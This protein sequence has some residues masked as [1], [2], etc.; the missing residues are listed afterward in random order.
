[1]AFISMYQFHSA[2][3]FS[4]AAMLSLMGMM[5]NDTGGFLRCHMVGGEMSA[6]PEAYA[7][8]LD[9]RLLSP[10]SEVR[11]EGCRVVLVGSGGVVHNFDKVVLATT[12]DVARKI[13]TTPSENQ[14]RFLDS[15][16][17]AATVNV[18]FRVP[19]GTLKG[20]ACVA[21]TYR[22]NPVICEYTNE[23]LKGIAVD[24]KTLVNV[25]LHE[26]AAREIIGKSDE[27]IYSFVK[28]ELLKVCPPLKGDASILENHDL[29][30][31]PQA[32]P[33]FSQKFVTEAARFWQRGQGNNSV[34][35]AGDM[36]GC[37]WVEGA[38]YS[39]KKVAKLIEA[40][41]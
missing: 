11:G 32:M 25:G 37:P 30:R 28:G 14:K 12:A 17:Y 31:W 18:S 20:I 36:T 10:I 38:I 7:K 9:V 8:G 29:E 6:I 41:I 27:E 24:G 5:I 1:D 34:Y 22:E 40:S 4:L 39:G 15:V 3:E 19:V 16:K 13:Y 33:K 2:R 26:G 21:I 23:E 35:F